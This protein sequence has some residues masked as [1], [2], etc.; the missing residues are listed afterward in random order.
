[1]S[2]RGNL[3]RSYAPFRYDDELH[4]RGSICWVSI[5][6]KAGTSSSVSMRPYR[7][8]DLRT[9]TTMKEAMGSAQDQ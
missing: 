2:S 6:L 9:F 1:M 8:L 7:A 5:S 4:V 3:S